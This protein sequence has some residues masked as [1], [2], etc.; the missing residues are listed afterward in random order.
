MENLNDSKFSNK[1]VSNDLYN[2]AKAA[3][4]AGIIKTGTQYT[5]MD[6]GTINPNATEKSLHGDGIAS[7]QNMGSEK[8]NTPC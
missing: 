1:P 2:K 3:I 6:K 8:T 5:A 4:A 7:K